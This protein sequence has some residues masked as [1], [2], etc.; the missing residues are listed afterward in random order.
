[1]TWLVPFLHR[2]A[3]EGRTVATW[4]LLAACLMACA[5]E[6]T[7]RP[8]PPVPPPLVPPLVALE[9]PAIEAPDLPWFT[10]GLAVAYP[11]LPCPTAWREVYT[12]T[13]DLACDPWPEGGRQ[14]CAE[15]GQAHLPGTPGCAAIGSSCDPSGWPTSLPVSGGAGVWY[16]RPGGGG[17]GSS[18]EAPLPTI[19]AALAVAQPGDTLALAAGTYDE[20]VALDAAVSAS[21]LVGACPEQTVLTRSACGAEGAVVRVPA[22]SSAS[23]AD[24]SVAGAPCAGIA[25][26]AASVHLEGVALHDLGG[27]G[28][29]ASAGASVVAER[30]VARNTGGDAVTARASTVDLAGASLA[31]E[32]GAGVRVTGPGAHLTVEDTA[33]GGGGVALNVAEGASGTLRRVVVDDVGGGGLRAADRETALTAADLVVNAPRGPC[34]ASTAGAELQV[35]RVWARACGEVGLVAEHGARLSASDLIVD[36]A[37]LRSEGAGSVLTVRRGVVAGHPGHGVAVHGARAEV[38]HVW[39]EGVREAGAAACGAAVHDGSLVLDVVRTAGNAHCGVRVGAGGSL[40]AQDVSVGDNAPGRGAG[41]DI[42]GEASIDRALVEETHGAGLRA[43]GEAQVSM[44]RVILR[45]LVP[46]AEGRLGEGV[47][48][49]DGARAMLGR[50]LVD[51]YGSTGVLALGASRVE[52]SHVRVNRGR[53]DEGGL[54]GEG[55]VARDAAQIVGDQVVVRRARQVGVAVLEGAELELTTAFV[56]DTEAQ[57][58]VDTT[59]PGASAAVGA[60]A[61]GGSLVLADFVLLD[62]ATLGAFAGGGALDLRDGWIAGHPAGLAGPVVLSDVRTQRNEEARPSEGPPE[63]RVG[64]P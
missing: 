40:R 8:P 6:A 58:C 2:L 28:I 49:E 57:A 9:E 59:C 44:S 43:T 25:A 51:D 42:A 56:A 60:Y 50:V 29:T 26:E 63:I 38:V 5:S 13:S 11:S 31:S 39:M 48:L 45:N 18:A 3:T 22:G 1:M 55:L 62:N 34:V 23:L 14:A 10:S 64:A 47:R 17:D 53:G 4:G 30:L 37:G 52:V 35:D 20:A 16:V 33:F 61:G 21:A 36:G 19:A 7:L 15:P 24:L 54:G 46:D 32:S 41:F 12:P 27:A